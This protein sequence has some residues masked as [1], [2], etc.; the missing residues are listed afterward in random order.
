[1]GEKRYKP[2][3][4]GRR[5]MSRRDFS[6]ITKTKPEKSLTKILKKKSGR[7]N[8][9]HISVR[10]KGGGHRRKYR[11]IDFARNKDGVPGEV[12]AIE[13]D[14]NRSAR[15]ALI[16][17]KDGEKRY[18]LAPK[19]LKV[20]D[21]VKSGE[22]AEIKIG[23]ALKLKDIPIGTHIHN[24][25]LRPGKGGKLVKSAGTMAQIVARED[26]YVH[27]Q[28]PSTEVRLVHKDCKATIG[29]LS[30]EEHENVL[31]G[32]AGRNRWRGKRPK[33]RGVAMNPVD[34]PHGGGEGRTGQG[35][36][37]PVSPWG[38]LAK[39]QKKRKKN[40]YSDRF[41]VSRRKKK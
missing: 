36:P 20:E 22:D 16:Q 10:R 19:G 5:R 34:H 31:I 32:K 3:T 14:P 26:K 21:I 13:Y 39:G 38:K 28:L 40:K 8:Y 17:Y 1:M 24:I 12:K 27:I 4:P 9:G 25:E 6:T 11:I 29:Q 41:I 2:T 37:H 30:N 23:H 18:I 15:I 33:V 35:N 7:D